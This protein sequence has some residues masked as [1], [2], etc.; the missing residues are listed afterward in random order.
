M[1]LLIARFLDRVEG[2]VP[3]VSKPKTDQL[4]ARAASEVHGERPVVLDVDDREAGIRNRRSLDVPGFSPSPHAIRLNLLDSC[5][6]GALAVVGR[7]NGLQHVPSGQVR[8]GI[9]PHARGT[10]AFDPD[11]FDGWAA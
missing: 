4:R 3:Y 1:P 6:E 9:V 7:G 2:E 8:R 5:D 11:R 10:E